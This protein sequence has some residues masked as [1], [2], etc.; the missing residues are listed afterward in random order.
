[1]D[2]VDNPEND[3][4]NAT[5]I[6][7]LWTQPILNVSYEIKHYWDLSKLFDIFQVDNEVS[8]AVL[9]SGVDFTNPNLNLRII[10]ECRSFV[11]ADPMDN[12]G[13]GTHLISIIN[14]IAPNAKIFA[15]KVLH[16]SSDFST[17]ALINGLEWANKSNC[18]ICLL[19]LGSPALDTELK[20]TLYELDMGGMIIICAEANSGMRSVSNI[21]YPAKFGNVL[22]IGSHDTHGCKSDFSSIGREI[23]F[24][25][26][27]ESVL[28]YG[29]NDE[30]SERR[31]NYCPKK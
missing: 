6:F 14:D 22:C 8:V 1:M 31:I 11:Q 25:A 21:T 29:I 15:G 23:D 12:I 4:K 7:G 5:K 10:Q 30:I 3:T 24:L 28:G 17:T 9:D 18:K 27:G 19:A 16:Q 2:V 26:P 20:K 13:H